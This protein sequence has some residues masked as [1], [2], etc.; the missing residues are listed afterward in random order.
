MLNKTGFFTVEALEAEQTVIEREQSGWRIFRL[1]SNI[2]SKNE[3][4]EGVRH[5]L[6]L[7]PALHSNRSWDALADSL[8]AGLDSLP[9]ER[10]VVVWPDASLMEAQAPD[11]FAIATNVLT[12][13]PI[14][15]ADVEVTAGATKLLLILRVI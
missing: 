10:I 13:L 11:D 7:D 8:W 14:S 4:F 9:E 1:P 12:E 3:F 15:L 5:T 6:P 2:S